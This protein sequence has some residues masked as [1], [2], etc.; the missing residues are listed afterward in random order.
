MLALK[1]YSLQ[2]ILGLAVS[3]EDTLKGALGQ[4]RENAVLQNIWKTAVRVVP[5]N[6]L[7]EESNLIPNFEAK[8]AEAD[9]KLWN[10][11]GSESPPDMYDMSGNHQTWFPHILTNIQYYHIWK[12]LICTLYVNLPLTSSFLSFSPAIVKIFPMLLN[13]FPKY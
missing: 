3:G 5:L 8:G 9:D 6:P 4:Y 2:Q 10:R 1:E 7:C 11:D 12:C 13:S